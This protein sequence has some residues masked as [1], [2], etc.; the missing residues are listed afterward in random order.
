MRLASCSRAASGL[1]A[2]AARAFSAAAARGG[3]GAAAP[4][5][6]LPLRRALLG[7]PLAPGARRAAAGGGAPRGF[8]AAPVLA[9]LR[10]G[11]VGL[12]NVGALAFSE[13]APRLIAPNPPPRTF[14]SRA[15]SNPLI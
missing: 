1:T 14:H 5:P 4:P 10:T 9:G 3:G 11:I 8:R 7:R 15:L 13:R 6:R 12:P 2:M